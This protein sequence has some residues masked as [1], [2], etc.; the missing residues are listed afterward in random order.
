MFQYSSKIPTL[1]IVQ[2][3]LLH[4]FPAKQSLPGASISKL[5]GLTTLYTP[6]IKFWVPAAVSSQLT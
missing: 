6:Q 3:A 5:S 1:D 4:A 2:F